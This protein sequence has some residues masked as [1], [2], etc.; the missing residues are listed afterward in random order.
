[1]SVSV[2][3]ILND[4]FSEINEPNGT[5][6]NGGTDGRDGVFS[7]TDMLGFLNK[8]RRKLQ[9]KVGELK[10]EN[11][12]Q[13]IAEQIL[14]DYPF[15][16]KSNVYR[17]EYDNKPLLKTT[18]AALDAYDEEWRNSEE[19]NPPDG[20]PRF[21]VLDEPDRKFIVYPPPEESGEIV[22]MTGF[23]SLEE[24]TIGGTTTDLT[25]PGSLEEISGGGEVFDLTDPGS[26]EEIVTQ[27][28]NLKLFYY[29][30]LVDL[31]T[32][33]NAIIE[34]EF[35]PHLEAIEYF[36]KALIYSSQVKLD[37]NLA[38]LNF[39]LFG[40]EARE[41]KQEKN[42]LKRPMSFSIRRNP[43][44]HWGRRGNEF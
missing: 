10:G 27:V 6:A 38:R 19:R 25:G 42:H 34:V 3:S 29:K 44:K 2:T 26:L 5:V 23:G 18:L 17:L 37:V 9:R 33:V 8:S 24:V 32:E 12:I 20:T 14:Y 22:D 4:V 28:N 21:Y 31:T 13:G 41:I 35:E 39:D 11:R 43:G 36:M 7:R 16:F 30:H 1:M 15:D 40:D